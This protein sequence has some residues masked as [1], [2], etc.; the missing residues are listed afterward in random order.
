MENENDNRTGEELLKS[1]GV[2]YVEKGTNPHHVDTSSL[3]KK[4]GSVLANIMKILFIL[5]FVGW[6]YIV[7]SDYSLVK[8]G[9]KPKY[10]F[11]DKKVYEYPDGSIKSCTG[12]G[13]KVVNYEKDGTEKIRVSEFVP[14]WIKTK[15]L[16]EL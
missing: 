6:A 1:T 15:S 10:C 7:Y 11:F 13:Y 14:I 8:T 3:D 2:N 16:D 9:D 4:K 5:L 12:L